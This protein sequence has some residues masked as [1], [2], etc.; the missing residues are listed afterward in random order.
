[1]RTKAT[2]V[3]IVDKD[4]AIV[5]VQRRA[6]C[7]GCH[8]NADGKECSVCTLLGGDRESR[9]RAANK[10]GALAGDT[11]IVE[12]RTRRILSYAALVF[13]LPVLMSI[14]GF[15]LGS[16]FSMGEGGTLLCALACFLLSFVCIWLYSRI[17][18]SKRLDVEIVEIVS[19]DL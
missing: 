19:S 7:D 18:I 15:A 12:S 1:M 6:A 3:E 4:V 13:M 2:V 11:V 8:K 14:L 17:V 5:S 10:V 9:S 16:L